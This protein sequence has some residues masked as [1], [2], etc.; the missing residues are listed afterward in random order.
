MLQGLEEN[1]FNLSS[2]VPKVA[3]R[4][5]W[6]SQVTGWT[7]LLP[8]AFCSYKQMLFILGR[9]EVWPWISTNGK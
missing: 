1:T 6:K 4:N 2:E 8:K 7:G 3:E 5:G 9:G